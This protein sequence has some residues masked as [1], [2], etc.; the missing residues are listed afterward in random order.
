MS[1]ASLIFI[2]R[3]GMRQ[4]RRAPYTQLVA[5]TLPA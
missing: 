5:I 1:Y 2:E 3:E 4:A